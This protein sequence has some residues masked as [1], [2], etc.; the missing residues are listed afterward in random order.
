MSLNLLNLIRAINSKSKVFCCIL[1]LLF[2]QHCQSYFKKQLSYSCVD[3][4]FEDKTGIIAADIIKSSNWIVDIT[5]NHY[6]VRIIISMCTCKYASYDYENVYQ[7]KRATV[8]SYSGD[9]APPCIVVTVIPADDNVDT[10]PNLVHLVKFIGME[11]PHDIVL[12]KG[13]VCGIN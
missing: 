3:L 8:E 9:T 13:V 2:L 7:V 5:D 10:F 12:K 4:S 1:S 11:Q 6:Q